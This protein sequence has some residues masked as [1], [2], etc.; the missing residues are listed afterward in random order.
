MSISISNMVAPERRRWIYNLAVRQGSV[1]VGELAESLGVGENTIRSDLDI[2]HQEG[3]LQRVHGGAVMRAVA[4]PRPP[5]SETRSTNL[6]EKSMIGAAALAYLPESG[7]VFI[8]SGT[9]TYQL[10]TRLNANHR[11]HTITNSLEIA[12]HLASHGVATVDF[13][14]GSINPDSLESDLSLSEEVL[15]KLYWD[16]T[17]MGVAAIDTARG[18]TTLDRSA[19]RWERLAIEHGRKTVVLCDSSKFERYSY[20]QVGDVSLIDVLITDA[21]IRHEFKEELAAQGV[22]V[23]I[24]GDGE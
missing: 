2:L 23:V 13:L 15:D 16:V 24:A 6:Q 14:G 22:E 12:A 8:G 10:A 4:T 9:T 19:A 20:A 1:K 18:I 21:G 5:Y 3:K 11:L 7:T 17:F